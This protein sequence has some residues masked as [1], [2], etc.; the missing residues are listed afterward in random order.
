MSESMARLLA[1][2]AIAALVL[3]WRLRQANQRMS[4]K[5]A[6]GSLSI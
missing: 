5:M 1:G 2:A 6:A 4:A 3:V